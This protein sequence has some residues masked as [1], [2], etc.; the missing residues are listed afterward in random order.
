MLIPPQP[1]ASRL[2][3]E[4]VT[5]LCVDTRTPEL[6]LYAMR[7]SMR[8]I[9]FGRCILISTSEARAFDLNGI[10]LIEIEPLRNIEDYSRYILQSLGPHL[11]TSHALIVQWDGFV[12]DAKMWSDDFLRF[13]YIGAP[14][15]SGPL[16]GLVGNGGFSL[17]SRKLL[18]A[19][20]SGNY[21]AHNPED[22][23]I[24]VTHR[25]SLEKKHQIAFAD[26]HTAQRFACERGTWQ[27]AFGFH[28][29]FNLPHVLTADELA[30][31]AETVPA[32]L[33]ASSDAR[34]L[35]RNLV[36]RGQTAPAQML[37]DKRTAYLG[38]SVDTVRQ[39]LQVTWARLLGLTPWSRR[40]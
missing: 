28:A 33:T 16:T 36:R 40:A 3:L 34:H 35:I 18:Q 13:D 11:Q 20:A 8:D 30:R 7:R 27:P 24:A 38:W 12:R 9:A 22:I 14:W 31:F 2:S 29:M 21:E 4:Q 19:L 10:D 23:C 6:A 32:H 17:R 25:T 5:L 37:L 15:T 26:L 39:N 1:A